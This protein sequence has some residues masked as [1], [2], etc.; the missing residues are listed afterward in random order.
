MQRLIERFG[1]VATVAPSM[2]EIPL[3]QND[4]ALAFGERLF[5]GEIDAVI[6]LTGVG[7][8]ALVD[9]LSTRYATEDVLS[10]FR[11]TTL[12]VRGPKPTAVLKQWKLDIAHRAPEPNTWR[13]LIETLRRETD[14]SGKTVAV[15]EY[16]RPNEQFYQELRAL[17]ATVIAAPVYRWA[18]PEDTAPLEAA[19]RSAT[20]GDFDALLFT[21]ANQVDNC[22]EIADRTVGKDRFITAVK[23]SAVCSIGPTCSEA[24]VSVGLMP[25]VEASP[26]KMGQL[27]RAAFECLANRAEE[28]RS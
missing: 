6:F 14:L 1:G 3:E 4:E 20:D 16:G 26:P 28:S 13:E 7:A 21:S 5:A 24:L 15:Q 12:I 27:V 23:Q 22:L 25:D 17:G 9:A 2:R 19:V 8:R 18:L 10:Q 11:R